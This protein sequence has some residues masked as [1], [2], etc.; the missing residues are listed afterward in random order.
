MEILKIK[1][2]KKWY[3]EG[4][5]VEMK[6]LIPF[7]GTRKWNVFYI[8]KDEG[9]AILTSGKSKKVFLGRTRICKIP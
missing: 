7:T 3:R 8:S 2:N 1:I 5:T 6:R 9:I 4:D